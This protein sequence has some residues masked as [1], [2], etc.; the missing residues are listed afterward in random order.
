MRRDFAVD[1]AQ[2]PRE[3]GPVCADQHQR[4]RRISARYAFAQP[5]YYLL[6]KKPYTDGENEANQM[7]IDSFAAQG[8]VWERDEPETE[9]VV[10]KAAK[11][12]LKNEPL[13]FVKKTFIGFFAFW[14]QPTSRAN[15]LF[16]GSLALGAWALALLGWRRAKLEGRP[17]WP[18]LQPILTV[19]L[20]YAALLAL[21]RYSAPTI[22]T[23]MVL[24]AWGL[25]SLL[26]R[27]WR[28]ADPSRVT[29][30]AKA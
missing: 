19:N 5:K 10:S 6:Q 25:D 3:R 22:P 30:Q 8:L 14:Y 11:E 12:K 28:T 20:L 21:G 1:G 15:S 2:L 13:A 16:V 17:L 7:E 29:S 23:L 24:A 26:D 18:L 27:S 4:R 9:R